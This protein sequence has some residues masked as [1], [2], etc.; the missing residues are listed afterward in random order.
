M[1]RR[2]WLAAGSNQSSRTGG[3]LLQEE[4]QAAAPWHLC[5]VSTPA[6]MQFSAPTH[7]ETTGTHLCNIQ[8]EN[9]E[10]EA[11]GA[12]RH[13]VGAAP[14][15]VTHFP[16]QRQHRLCL[17]TRPPGPSKPARHRTETWAQ[18]SATLSGNALSSLL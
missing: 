9:L 4:V 8:E 13:L 1:G 3:S 17:G 10:E 14:D 16:A 18:V 12:A 15:G 6:H 7:T 2:P 5:T 11:Q